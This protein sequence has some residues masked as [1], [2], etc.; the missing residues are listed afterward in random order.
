[1]PLFQYKVI[2]VRKLSIATTISVHPERGVVVRAPF[3]LSSSAIQ[4]FVEEKSEWINKHLKKIG[5]TVPEKKYL[6]GEMHLYFG[7]EY[8]LKINL[9]NTPIRTS[10]EMAENSIKVDLYQGHT[11]D[12]KGLE[13]KEGLLRWYLETGISVITEK[14][15]F[16]TEKVGVNY[17]RIDIKKVSSIW[18]SCS[19][20]NRLSFNRKLIMAPHEV[21]DYVIIHEI[22]HLV[23]RNHSSRFWAL[24]AK[25]DPKYKEHRRWLYRNHLLL[26]I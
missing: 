5:S 12:K 18:G 25:Y 23:H 8:P 16:Y 14:V 21:V 1:M 11:E 2:R 9:I 13:I 19:P 4:K 10:V 26:S 6:E 17:S 24:V 15:N 22:C 7:Q 20:N 3:W